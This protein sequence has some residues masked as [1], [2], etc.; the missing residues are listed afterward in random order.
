LNNRFF[1][2]VSEL[3]ER[4]VPFEIGLLYNV[5][6]YQSPNTFEPYLNNDSKKNI[7]Y[8]LN[9]ITSSDLDKEG[10]K[11]ED[12]DVKKFIEISNY[13]YYQVKNLITSVHSNLTPELRKTAEEY[14]EDIRPFLT[15]FIYLNEIFW[16]GILYQSLFQ[17]D[18]SPAR[19]WE[20]YDI[21]FVNFRENLFY[22][23]AR[24]RVKEALHNKRI[25][26]H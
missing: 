17:F 19:V 8:Y 4:D 6:Y 23:D 11:L 13:N 10:Y 9:L 3:T 2:E 5:F 7:T 24:F 14:E 15:M 22:S 12:I 1:I 20:N 21:N 16:S 18:G 25:T 26:R